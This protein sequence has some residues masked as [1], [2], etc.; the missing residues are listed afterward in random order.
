MLH[1]S[2]ENFKNVSEQ[3]YQNTGLDYGLGLLW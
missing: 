1:T 2:S 3:S